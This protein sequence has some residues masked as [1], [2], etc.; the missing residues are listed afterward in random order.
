[1]DT[2]DL[3]IIKHLMTSARATWAELG[4]M[5]GLSAPAAAD[6]VHRLEETG[7]IKGYAAVIAP[8]AVGCNL[9]ALVAVTLARP[10]H[11][12]AFLRLVDETPEI[13]E[14]HHVAG[15]EDYILKVRCAG[16]EDLEQLVSNDIKSLPGIA[17]TRTTIILSTVKETVAL[18]IKN[19]AR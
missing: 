14:C 19:S 17:K 5:L 7:V 15:E 3:K 8:P 18:P 11:R 9:T 12:P 6:R 10:R 13:Q 4:T 16:T 2:N 1:M